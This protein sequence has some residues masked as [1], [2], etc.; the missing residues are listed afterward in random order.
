MI[1]REGE[2]AC[3]AGRLLINLRFK[4]CKGIREI[5]DVRWVTNSQI[6]PSLDNRSLGWRG[7]VMCGH[8]SADSHIHFCAPTLRRL[9]TPSYGASR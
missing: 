1:S 4:S 9:P 2:G 3:W 7:W 5:E 6:V 8:V